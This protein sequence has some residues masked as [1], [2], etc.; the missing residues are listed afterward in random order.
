MRRFGG[1]PQ[2]VAWDE[3]PP[4]NSPMMGID[5]MLVAQAMREG[6]ALVSQDEALRPYGVPLIW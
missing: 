6:A 3:T 2:T 4:A 5:R 1:Y